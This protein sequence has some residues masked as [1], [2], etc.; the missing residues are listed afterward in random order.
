MKHRRGSIVLGI[1]LAGACAIAA[2]VIPFGSQPARAGEGGASNSVVERPVPDQIDFNRDVRPVLSDNCYA[3]HGPDKNKR[4]ADLRLDTKDGLMSSHDD[5]HTVVAGKPGESELFR[6][7]VAD[8]PD[9]RMPDPK[10]NKRLTPREIAVLKKWIEQGA[11]YKGHWAFLKPARPDVPAADEPGFVRNPVD[12]FILARLKEERLEHA[13]EADRVTLLRRVYFDLTGLPPTKDE[14][15]A[16][17]KDPSPDA[18]DKVVDRLLASPA[19]GERMAE[20]WLDL[21]RYADSIGYHSDNPMN[22]SPYREYVI[23]SFNTNKPFDRFSVEQIAGDLLP[24]PT[25]E[26]KVATAYNRLLQTTEEGGAQPKEYEQK[27]LADRVRNVSTVWLA[28]TMGCCQCHDHKFDPFAQKDFYSMGAFFADVQEA[29]VGKREP[30]M[31]VPDAKQSEELKKMDDA[32]AAAR[33]RLEQETPELAEAQAEWEKSHDEE[34]QWTA[35]EPQ[36]WQVSGESKL[37]KEPDGVLRSYYK[38]AAK[39]TYTVTVKTDAKGITGFRLEVLADDEL[40]D[41]GPGTAPNGNFVLT[42]FKVTALPAPAEGSDKPA[43]KPQPVKLA[44]AT[45]DHSQDGFPIANAIDAKGDTGWA[46]LPQ[47]GKPHAAVFETDK[48]LATGDAAGTTFT[49]TLAFNSPSPQHNIG[50]FRLSATTTPRPA[51]RVI[52]PAV[53]TALAIA[54]D[55]RTDGQKKE[56]AG[57]YRTIAPLLEPVRVELASIEKQKADLLKTVPTCLVSTPGN[58]RTVRVLAR[59]NWQDESGTVVKPAVPDSLGRL[60]SSDRRLTRLDLANWLVSKE[61]P[62]T[63][64]VFV[65]RLWKLYFGQG[66]SK[67]LDDFGAQG[68][69]PTHPEL[70]DWLAVEFMNPPTRFARSGQVPSVDSASSPQ[71][72]SGQEVPALSERSESKWDIK[73]MVRLLVTSGTYRL[74]SKATPEQKERD[75]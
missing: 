6:R 9:E 38:V 51:G 48:P 75:P 37:R 2:A 66:L 59:G 12:Q 47:I 20:Y 63:A 64:R 15:D 61:N 10:S 1:A 44:K 58:P 33:K 50:K 13:P 26:Q 65:N 31:P 57:Y 23:Q 25:I 74:A 39:E 4:K 49:F 35:L 27:Y 22:V 68:E 36:A 21:V 40:P 60:E 14:V 52:P 18:Y 5:I 34:V 67:V 62:L 11:A 29:S 70:L 24:N 45:A 16:F 53:K 3:C 42:D 73:H 7:V 17:V 46:V 30:G 71:T 19:F 55:E 72:S 41:H 32:L 43:G 56:I 54:P 28:A 8:D 69:W